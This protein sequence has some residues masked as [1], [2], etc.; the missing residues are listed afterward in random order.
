MEGKETEVTIEHG[1]N[2]EDGIATE[3]HYIQN[4]ENLCEYEPDEISTDHL[5]SIIAC[6]H[7]GI[8]KAH[9]SGVCHGNLKPS[10]ILVQRNAQGE[11]EG[12]ITEFGLYR[13]NLFTPFGLSEEEKK[14]VSVINMDSRASSLIGEGFRPD[15]VD[16]LEMPEETWDLFALGKIAQWAIEKVEG[17]GQ[18]VLQYLK[19]AH[20]G[21]ELRKNQVMVL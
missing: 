11:W 10:N 9:L 18:I 20:F 17:K 14:E 15:G 1:E 2:E 19:F 12:F 5:L 6:L 7:Q 21:V 13:L 4:L 3:L 8:Y 16:H